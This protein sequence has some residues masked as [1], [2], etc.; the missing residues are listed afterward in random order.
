[1][2]DNSNSD[3]IHA[4][5]NEPS[6]NLDVEKNL[7]IQN[8]ENQQNLQSD[9]QENNN[10]NE[11]EN[12][13]DK[14]NGENAQKDNQENNDNNEKEK[15]LNMENEDNVQKEQNEQNDNNEQENHLNFETGEKEQNDNQE[16]N[17]NNENEKDLNMDNRENDL[18]ENQETDN[19][20]IKKKKKIESLKKEIKEY[21]ELRSQFKQNIKDSDEFY[22]INKDWLKKWKKYTNYSFLKRGWNN[23]DFDEDNNPG[24][25]NN[26]ELI[27]DTSKFLKLKD[28]NYLVIKQNKK[29]DLKILNEELFNFFKNIYDGGPKIQLH[30][31]KKGWSRYEVDAN[32]LEFDLYFLPKKSDFEKQKKEIVKKGEICVNRKI[33]IKKL[34]E[35]ILN[36]IKEHNLENLKDDISLENYTEYMRFYILNSEI[37]EIEKILEEKEKEIIESKEP[38][39]NITDHNLEL[40][41]K[42]NLAT[43]YPEENRSYYYSTN[44]EEIKVVNILIDLAPF[45]IVDKK[46][47]L[48]VGNCEYCRNNNILTYPCECKEVWY[49]NKQCYQKDRHFHERDCKALFKLQ[50]EAEDKLEK[51]ENSKNGLVGLSNLGNTCYMNT[52]LQCLSN[53]WELTEYFLSN[54]YKEDI[55]ENNP[56]GSHGDLARAYGGVLKHLWYGSSSHYSPDNFKKTLGIYQKM[57]SG[58]QQQDTQEFLNYLLDGLHEDLNKVLNKPIVVQDERD[59]PDEIKS[60]I[61]WVNFLR[62]NQ[63]VLV[64]LF[65]GQFKSTLI[66]PNEECKNISI[67]FDPFLNLSLPL[68]QPIEAYKIDTYFIFDNNDL[69]MLKIELCFYEKEIS[70]LDLRFKIAEILNIHPFSFIVCSFDSDYDIKILHA[71]KLIKKKTYYSNIRNILL[72]QIPLKYFNNP[73][74][75]LKYETSLFNQFS[76]DFNDSYIE[77]IK[78]NEDNYKQINSSE[79][80]SK[81]KKEDFENFDDN[82]L[83]NEKLQK[84]L[85]YS[86]MNGEDDKLVHCKYTYFEK[87]CTLN[88]LYKKIF[89]M[90]SDVIL[91]YI[92]SVISNEESEYNQISEENKKLINELK[93]IL[94]FKKENKDFCLGELYKKLFG[95]LN[96]DLLLKND[97]V[98]INETFIPF[99]LKVGKILKSQFSSGIK[100][101]D[102]NNLPPSINHTYNYV[103]EKFKESQKESNGNNNDEIENNNNNNKKIDEGFNLIISW[104]SRLESQLKEIM[105]NGDE[106]NST[107]ESNS[108]H[109]NIY[110]CFEQLTKPERLDEQNEW[111]CPKC[112]QFQR[113]NKKIDIYKTPNILIIQLKRFNNRRKIDTTVDFPINNLDISKYV[114][115]K[116]KDELKYDLFAIGNHFG[117]MGFGH[118]IAYC[119]N[120]FDNVWYE[121]NDSSVSMVNENHLISSSAYTLFYKRKGIE[122]INFNEIYNKK[123]VNYENVNKEEENKMNV[124]AQS[125]KESEKKDK[126]DDKNMEDKKENTN[127][128]INENDT[129]VNNEENKNEDNNNNMNVENENNNNINENKENNNNMNVDNDN[130]NNN[131]INN[132]NEVNNNNIN[133]NN[134]NVNNEE[135]KNEDNNNNMNVENENN[136]DK[137]EN[138]EK[139]ENK[140]NKENKEM[141]EE[142]PNESN[143]EENND[144]KN[145]D[146]N[147]DE[148]NKNEVNKNEKKNDENEINNNMDVEK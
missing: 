68:P 121:F 137:K 17:N 51:N 128:I 26:D 148:D 33:N 19:E 46:E 143:I 93:T 142:A 80:Q 76:K 50:L 126:N 105:Q 77:N 41:K 89:L 28:E 66:C 31:Q 140:E 43:L 30:A 82:C 6:N 65:Y 74:F 138:E 69:K 115:S 135:N 42:F 114:I 83:D 136:N 58:Y 146:Q 73:E 129:N 16:N 8:G 147:N 48:K 78:Q 87:D 104:N 56:I 13:L 60:Q 92:D 134:N 116:T 109:I 5:L 54:K 84:T 2:E 23:I 75:N 127:N 131:N 36:I 96:E 112:K 94:D 32:Y 1:M 103:I 21:V 108:P 24:K 79:Y 35:Y 39:I 64:D 14:Q 95:E 4:N 45:I 38:I 70:C 67:T 133:D 44:E 145:K 11:Q 55:N 71:N 124:D 20:E 18:N 144:D 119:K 118:Y 132:E 101:D 59:N 122:K 27:F 139:K 110:D 141:N 49:C 102:S 86:F 7:N 52:S 25:I 61:Y 9:K 98:N 113:A 130:N 34:I 123:F 29:N 97:E 107:E 100:F 106:L 12:N 91:K 53:C 62:R 10:H 111:Y 15:E 47:E 37:N 88:S 90:F 3:G 22:I 72:F 125:T 117:S 120:H 57:F 85:I 99:V 63:S 81:Y 40:F